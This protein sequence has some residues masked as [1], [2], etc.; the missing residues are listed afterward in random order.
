MTRQEKGDEEKGDGGRFPQSTCL[1]M[2]LASYV[3]SS[4]IG[5]GVSGKSR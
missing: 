4:E 2:R 5:G 3:C 1:E